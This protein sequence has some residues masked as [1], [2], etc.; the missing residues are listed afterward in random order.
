MSSCTAF[1]HVVLSPIGVHL[2]FPHLSL[3]FS[4]FFSTHSP[5]SRG[6]GYLYYMFYNEF[7]DEGKN[8]SVCKN[9]MRSGTRRFDTM[10]CMLNAVFK[11]CYQDEASG[12]RQYRVA[13]PRVTE[14]R[15][16]LDHREIVG[17]CDVLP[18]NKSETETWTHLTS[19][20]DPLPPFIGQ[21]VGACLA[22]WK[23]EPMPNINLT[24]MQFYEPWR[25]NVTAACLA[26]FPEFYMYVHDTLNAPFVDRHE[27]LADLARYDPRLSYEFLNIGSPPW[28]RQHVA[29]WGR[30]SKTEKI[31]MGLM[32]LNKPDVPPSGA[33]SSKDSTDSK[34]PERKR[35]TT[36]VSM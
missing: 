35:R 27:D 30:T 11:K 33:T 20:S 12:K 2:S 32:K 18:M 9:C 24:S 22:P 34:S 25:T 19:S 5:D 3:P 14:Q 21:R 10:N 31:L 36:D 6:F 26:A 15:G 8:V 16:V 4:S 28:V 23:G 29:T 17:N 1:F 7:T 13:F